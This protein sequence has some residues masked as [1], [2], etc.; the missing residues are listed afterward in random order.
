M[1]LCPVNAGCVCTFDVAVRVTEMGGAA[2]AARREGAGAAAGAAGTAGFRVTAI[3]G[4][5][6][7]S[8]CPVLNADSPPEFAVGAGRAVRADRAADPV[9]PPIPVFLAPAF[10]PA[11]R[12]VVATAAETTGA[13]AKRTPDGAARCGPEALIAAGSEAR[14][15]DR[16]GMVDDLVVTPRGAATVLVPAPTDLA[17]ADPFFGIAAGSESPEPSLRED[18]GRKRNRGSSRSSSATTSAIYLHRHAMLPCLSNVVRM[19]VSARVAK[20]WRPLLT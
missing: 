10:I 16:A 4:R 17:W 7:L 3:A 12:D 5:P 8:F 20:Q 11:V 14:T 13:D 9:G 19:Q 18:E 1:P 15:V 2:V 6:G